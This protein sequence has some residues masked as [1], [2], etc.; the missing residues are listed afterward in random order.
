MYILHIHIAIL[1]RQLSPL[2]TFQ[3]PY[4]LIIQFSN[5]EKAK[6]ELTIAT[7]SMLASQS[8]H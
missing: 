7:K 8:N 3:L 6:T 5:L 1:L 4:S 2:A